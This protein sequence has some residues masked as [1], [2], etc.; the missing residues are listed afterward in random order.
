LTYTS[1]LLLFLSLG[2]YYSR[3]NFDFDYSEY[4]GPDWREELKKRNGKPAPTAVQ[5]HSFMMDGFVWPSLNEV[6]AHVSRASNLKIIG[7]A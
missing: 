3:E 1:K 7:I 4:L 5:N 2:L 6:R